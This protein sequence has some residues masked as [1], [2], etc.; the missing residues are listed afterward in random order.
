VGFIDDLPSWVV[1]AFHATLEEIEMAD[2]VLLVIDGS[3]VIDDIR[4]KI[5]VSLSELHDLK[6]TA[7]IIIL[8]NKYD[9]IDKKHGLELQEYIKQHSVIHS[10]PH[11]F[12]ST[13]NKKSITSIY[14]TIYQCLPNLIE[15]EIFLPITTEAQSLISY[16][17]S[18]TNV[19]NVEYGA[20]II[21]RL[22]SNNKLIPKIL[23]QVEQIKGRVLWEKQKNI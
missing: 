10:Y 23:N 16:L 12:I 15:I 20:E 2:I 9:L 1:D 13:K 19:Q 3:E 11:L 18:N 6:V 14:K 5:E 17:Y 4:R 8:F 7:P 22:V 21:V